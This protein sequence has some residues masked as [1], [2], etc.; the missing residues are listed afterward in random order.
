V[1][2]LPPAGPDL[3]S[4]RSGPDLL[5]RRL[6]LRRPQDAASGG[7]APLSAQPERPLQ[8]RRAEPAISRPSEDSDALRFT[9][10]VPQCLCVRGPGGGAGGSPSWRRIGGFEQRGRPRDPGRRD[11]RAPLSLVWPGVL[12]V[13]AARSPASPPPSRPV[14]P[15]LRTPMVVSA[16]LHAQILRYYHVEKWRRGTIARQLGVHRDVVARVLAQSGLPPMA[17]PSGRRASTRTCRSSSRP[18]RRSR[19]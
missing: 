18:S 17:P 19:P 3:Q 10:P 14:P 8:P 11:V 5:R 4:L 7:G 15:A 16:E 1:R 12:A 9:R 2:S 6:S 13:R